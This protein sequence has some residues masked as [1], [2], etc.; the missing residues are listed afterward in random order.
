MAEEGRGIEL[1][2]EETDQLNEI[3]EENS[4]DEKNTTR[5]I[6]D[7]IKNGEEK[8]ALEKAKALS[9][10]SYQNSKRAIRLVAEKFSP[11]DFPA[12]WNEY[13]DNLNK[14]YDRINTPDASVQD[15]KNFI[16][17]AEKY[18]NARDVFKEM[19]NRVGSNIFSKA[20]TKIS[21]W[22]ADKNP[23]NGYDKSFETML[24]KENFEKLNTP[25]QDYAE[26]GTPLPEDLKD[27]VKKVNND[28]S[29][30]YQDFEKD[31]KEIAD[32]GKSKYGKYFEILCKLAMLGGAFYLTIHIL[33]TEFSGC[34][35][36]VTSQSGMTEKLSCDYSGDDQIYCGCGGNFKPDSQGSANIDCSGD[37]SKFPPC[38]CQTGRTCSKDITSD[39]AISYNYR[40][41]GMFES[42][43][44][45]IGAIANPIIGDLGL[46]NLGKYLKY[47]LIGVAV[48]LG[49]YFLMKILQA[50]SSSGETEHT[51]GFSFRKTK[52]RKN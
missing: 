24:M 25:I 35:K 26:K 40:N 50:F 45:A 52:F 28:L 2:S 1:S 42:L 31:N 51:H 38:K 13:I 10:R 5:E 43:G 47:I 49:L 14:A 41:V 9:E 48:L 4:K 15:Y 18:S 20:G 29:K 27:R 39:G 23:I 6:T 19:S 12:Q 46:G 36:I 3:I 11:K 32:E 37:N 33:T 21:N 7:D 44:Q 16:D 17:T 8:V 34:Y 30:L 22:F